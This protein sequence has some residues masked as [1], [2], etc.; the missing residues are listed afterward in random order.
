MSGVTIW[1]NGLD[2]WSGGGGIPVKLHTSVQV[3]EDCGK[4]PDLRFF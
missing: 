1:K 4:T 3:I 2:L